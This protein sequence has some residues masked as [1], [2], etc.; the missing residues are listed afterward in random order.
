MKIHPPVWEAG[1][2]YNVRKRHGSSMPPSSLPPPHPLPFIVIRAK[3]GVS[4]FLLLLHMFSNHSGMRAGTNEYERVP[5]RNSTEKRP[6]AQNPHACQQKNAVACCLD[7]SCEP[8]RTSTNEYERVR[9]VCKTYM[10]HTH[11]EILASA[12]EYDCVANPKQS[13]SQIS[14]VL[15]TR[16]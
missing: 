11:S 1:P 8:V 9:N 12:K 4:L 7:C 16:N 2:Q 10:F 14:P 13:H 15:P 5:I 6:H 3:R